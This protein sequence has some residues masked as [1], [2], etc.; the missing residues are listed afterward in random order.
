MKKS[1]A[2]RLWAGIGIIL[3]AFAASGVI[4]ILAVT[5]ARDAAMRALDIT[6]PT[7]I[8]AERMDRSVLRQ[9]LLGRIYA[10]GGSEEAL[11]DIAAERV[12]YSK[13]LK[14]L[15]EIDN[16][17][18]FS[19]ADERI[20][21]FYAK[22]STALDN[23]ISTAGLAPAA[24]G[25]EGVGVDA[26]RLSA[27]FSA[28]QSSQD[29]LS[30]TIDSALRVRTQNSFDAS[31]ERAELIAGRIVASFSALSA[32]TV[33]I[34][35]L[36]GALIMRGIRKPIDSLSEMT[37]AIANGDRS[38]RA[39]GVVI[40]EFQP[41]ARSFDAMVE[42][43]DAAEQ[44]LMLSY[45]EQR[46]ILDAIPVGLLSIG[47]DYRIGPEY[48]AAAKELFGHIDLS[49]VAL[50]E[51]LYPGD[52]DERSPRRSDLRRYLKQLFENVTAD[53]DFLAAMNPVDRLTIADI[54]GEERTLGIG[55]E[56]IYNGER[57][58]GVLV[59][60][61]D[62]TETIRAERRLEEERMSRRREAEC[63]QSILTIGPLPLNEFIADARG[64]IAD[65][66]VGLR[67]DDG[68]A[69][70]SCFRTLHSLK[71]SAGSLGLE[72]VADVAHQAEDILR[73][74]RAGEREMD[75]E[76]GVAINAALGKVGEELDSAENLIE[77]LHAALSRLDE[78]GSDPGERDEMAEFSR[79]LGAL[80]VQL[81]NSLSKP[82][83]IVTDIGV[84]T[85]PRF[86]D[87]KTA[88]I[89]LVRNAADHGLED[90]FDRLFA[91]KPDRGTIKV[92]IRPA[93]DASGAVVI[94]VEDNGAGIDFGRVEKKAKAAGVLTGEGP[95]TDSRLLSCI[96]SPGF[97]TRDEASDVSGR[98]VGLDLVREL[99]RAANGTISVATE[100]GRG[101]RFRIRV[102][103]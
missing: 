82:I 60:V 88:I 19:P 34:A 50:D 93:G 77:R 56:R 58:S 100:K 89:H 18:T 70:N 17:F 63:I 103:A 36:A 13:A 43:L 3:V 1:L 7:L 86:K 33:A 53:P 46:K 27:S 39:R 20:E 14:S 101:T 15:G 40:A 76:T 94:D 49:G 52:D 10:T 98:G 31:I 47:A 96:F 2:L 12:N 85:I 16:G 8:A 30:A 57:V 48:S 65:I 84:P 80:A 22:F 87:M 44:E 37:T 24:E 83:S 41:L 21:A 102:P 72:A 95:F 26:L 9:H 79:Q 74:V 42:K 61:R 81:E 67:R 28:V 54:E 64:E 25:D 62:L 11:R 29:A 68:E 6:G 45:Y 66:R 97:S 5:R 55:F 73:D 4:S 59:S 75:V 51:V 32:L 38:A 99:V 78:I 92:R 71:G 91:N 69:V 90:T 35:V 23:L